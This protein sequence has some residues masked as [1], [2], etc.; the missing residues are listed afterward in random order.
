MY[1]AKNTG[2]PVTRARA[3]QC[4]RVLFGGSIRLKFNAREA[5][6]TGNAKKIIVIECL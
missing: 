5:N 4:S 2:G 1:E 3:R 6:K